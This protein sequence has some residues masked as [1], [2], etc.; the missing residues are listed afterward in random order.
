MQ[1]VLIFSCRFL[2]VITVVGMKGCCFFNVYMWKYF[3]EFY[4][5]LPSSTQV[6]ALIKCKAYGN[7]MKREGEREGFMNVILTYFLTALSSSVIWGQM[8]AKAINTV[9]ML[10]KTFGSKTAFLLS[11]LKFLTS[12]VSYSSDF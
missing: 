10:L 11:F 6:N 4:F 9:K 1:W 5:F 7:R 3:T 8:F 2:Y 12:T